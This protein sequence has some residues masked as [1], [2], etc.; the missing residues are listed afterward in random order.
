MD[1][2]GVFKKEKNN[3]DNKAQ[4]RQ[5]EVDEELSLVALAADESRHKGADWLINKAG[6]VIRRTI[7]QVDRAQGS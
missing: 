6:L 7:Y 1:E 2:N 3:A 5:M 4:V